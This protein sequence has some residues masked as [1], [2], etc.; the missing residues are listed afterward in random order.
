MLG[1]VFSI[2]DVVHLGCLWDVKV[3]IG[4][5]QLNSKLRRG[6]KEIES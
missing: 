2:L 3:K 5:R 1:D 4:S 6:R